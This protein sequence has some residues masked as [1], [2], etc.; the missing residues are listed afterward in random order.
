MSDLTADQ[1]RAIEW[2]CARLVSLYANLNDVADWEAV[3]NLYA[4]DGAMA[5]PTAPDALIVGRAA[6]LEA[7]RARP[8]RTTRHICA[9]IVVDVEGPTAA[10]AESAMLL[11]TGSGAPLVGSF[12]DRFIQTAEGWRFAERRGFLHFTS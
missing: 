2:E 7:F 3:A 12:H 11:F 9:N 8:P 6:I 4:V 5:R 1:R 10:R